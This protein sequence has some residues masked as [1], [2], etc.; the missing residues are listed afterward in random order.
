MRSFP[1]FPI[2]PAVGVPRLAP[3]LLA[4]AALVPSSHQRLQARDEHG[5]LV[6]RL[7]HVLQ[8]RGFAGHQA[9]RR[10]HHR[11]PELAGQLHDVFKLGDGG[12]D[13]GVVLV[14]DGVEELGPEGVLGAG[15]GPFEKH[16]VQAGEEVRALALD[17]A[18]RLV[19]T[20]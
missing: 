1:T 20:R 19:A 17:A 8:G 11:V 10:A 13:G 9:A 12:L 14:D 2:L 16:G 7:R 3:V 6:G 18:G 15:Q 4:H 5:P